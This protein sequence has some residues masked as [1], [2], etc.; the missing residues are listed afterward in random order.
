MFGLSRPAE[1]MQEAACASIGGDQWYAEKSEWRTV[2]EAKKICHRCPVKAQCLQLALDTNEMFGV[3][4]GLTAVQRHELR[5]NRGIPITAPQEADWH[6][7]AGGYRRHY[8]DKTNVCERCREREQLDRRLR[9][10]R[11]G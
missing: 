4:G 10:E 1:W 9:T 6:G 3:W 7:K 8:R 5:M 2:V 11:C